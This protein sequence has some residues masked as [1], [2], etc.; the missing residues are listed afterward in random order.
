MSAET[1][2]ATFDG[3]FVE[4][5][6]S[7]FEKRWGISEEE[8]RRRQNSAATVD[9]PNEKA[10]DDCGNRVTVTNSGV[11]VGHQIGQRPGEQTCPRHPR[12]NGSAGPRD[13]NDWE[14]K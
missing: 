10:C 13:L 12:R 4:T 14:G 8:F 11:E 7:E 9:A 5:T 3:E 6:K 1:K 2:Q